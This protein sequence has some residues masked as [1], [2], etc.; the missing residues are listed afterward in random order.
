MHQECD[1]RTRVL[2]RGVGLKGP[3]DGAIRIRAICTKR[4]NVGCNATRLKADVAVHSECEDSQVLQRA[5]VE[6][7]VVLQVFHAG[8]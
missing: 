5:S 3:E 6:P 7:S 2:D 8:Y 4:G 1:G